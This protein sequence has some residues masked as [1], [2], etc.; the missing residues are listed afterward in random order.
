ME[1]LETKAGV[2]L[3]GKVLHF[4]DAATAA[5]HKLGDASGFV[6]TVPLTDEVKG[7]LR[8]LLTGT[9]KNSV[10]GAPPAPAISEEVE[11][12]LAH[13]DEETDH[14]RVLGVERTAGVVEIRGAYLKLMKAFHPDNYF[15]RIGEELQTKLETA[16]QKVVSA[17]DIL[18]DQKRRDKYDISLGHFAGAVDGS[19]EDVKR[20]RAELEEYRSKNAA[21]IRKA[22]DLWDSAL[23]DE[24][25]GRLKDARSKV[26][27]AINF[28]PKNPMFERKLQQWG[29][30]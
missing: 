20:K 8:G 3:N 25:A 18:A 24:K 15:N 13:S 11:R 30:G 19:S 5:T 28:D 27:L 26:Q 7:P 16:Y 6:A 21:R 4:L 17:F 1:V 29:E 14:Y 10:F 12:F 22:K 23:E 9:L 2:H